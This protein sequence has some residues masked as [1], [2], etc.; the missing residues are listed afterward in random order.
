MVAVG[1]VEAVLLPFWIEVSARRLEVRPFT[2]RNLMEVDGML[3]GSQIMKVQIE[4]HARALIPYH[5]DANG[6]PLSIFEF[7]IGFSCA[8]GW[9]SHRRNTQSKG[10]IA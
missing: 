4:F 1:A 9:K 3:P 2:L 5:D 10:A 6:F 7:D 8:A